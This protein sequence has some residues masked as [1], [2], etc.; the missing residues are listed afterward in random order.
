MRSTGEVLG[1][2]MDA[3]RAHELAEEAAAA[4]R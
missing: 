4:H 3:D 2:A 1:L